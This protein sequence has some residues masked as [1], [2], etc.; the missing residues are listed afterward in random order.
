MISPLT[1][2]AVAFLLAIGAPALSTAQQSTPGA[3]VDVTAKPAIAL[4]GQPVT[5]SGAT[6]YHEKKNVATLL[7]KHESGTP[8]ATLTA[9]VSPKGEFS[10]TFADTKKGGKYKVSVTAPDGT[11]KGETE[12][13]VDSVGAIVDEVEHVA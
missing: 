7:V 8:S 1:R 11:G 4:P 3:F 13:R 12:F 9:T 10:V 6:G 5:I 2:A